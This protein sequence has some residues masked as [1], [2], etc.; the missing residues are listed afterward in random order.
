MNRDKGGGHGGDR[1]FV[2]R[3][4]T[5]LWGLSQTHTC[6]APVPV[7]KQNMTI[8]AF[9][10]QKNL[11]LEELTN[12]FKAKK[13]ELAA[14]SVQMNNLKAMLAQKEQ[15]LSQALARPSST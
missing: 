13:A 1:S 2:R 4:E 6:L 10:M 12:Q 5:N 8:H 11:S 9:G 7:F 3:T 15:M 14:T